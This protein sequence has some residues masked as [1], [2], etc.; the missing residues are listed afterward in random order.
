MKR[1]GIWLLPLTLIVGVP[2][3][4]AGDPFV[5]MLPVATPEMSPGQ[6]GRHTLSQEVNPPL[7]IVGDD[8]LSHRWLSAKRDYLKRIHAVGMVVNVKDA[9]G[10]QRMTQYGLTMYP[11]RGHDFAAAFHLNH[12]PVLIERHQ[13]KQ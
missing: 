3:V 11:V 7:F 13:V 6:V 2:T 1:I 8:A 5:Q 4:F 12:Y 9:R 10:W